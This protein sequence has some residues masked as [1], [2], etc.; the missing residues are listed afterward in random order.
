MPGSQPTGLERSVARSIVEQ[1]FPSPV[2]RSP[3]APVT[4]EKVT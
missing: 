2:H 1:M 3:T 4:K